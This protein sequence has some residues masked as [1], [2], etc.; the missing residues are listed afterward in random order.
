MNSCAVE[1][2]L[3]RISESVSDVEAKK[4]RTEYQRIKRRKYASLICYSGTGYLG[5]QRNPGR[6]TIEEDLLNAMLKAGAITEEAYN[7]PKVIEFQRAAR[8]DKG[9]SAVRQILSLKLPMEIS[10]EDI[11]SHLPE[12][13]RMVAVKRATKGFNCKGHCDAR[14]Y[15]YMMPS[16]ALAPKECL[17]EESYRITDDVFDKTNELLQ[18]FVGTHNY[19]NFTSRK[20]P[21][22]PSAQRYIISFICERPVLTEGME[23][24]VLKVKG[25]SFM[26]HQ[27]RK[28]VGLVIAIMRGVTAKETVTKAWG[29]EKLDLPVAPGVGLVLEEVHYDRY[30]ERYSKDGFHDA[31]E[32]SA[33]KEQ[34]EEFKTKYILSSI[35]QTEK[36]EKSMLLW[37]ENL[38]LHSFD[39]RNGSR[40]LVEDEEEEDD[41][42]EEDRNESS[43]LKVENDVKSKDE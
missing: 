7:Q 38:P 43:K 36:D 28:M 27:I 13:I 37:L 8:T 42:A 30:N 1:N 26:L 23:F 31:I 5:L 11:N 41:C 39:V 22:D 40:N 33:V 9:V 3:K 32:W 10:L 20:K 19:H 2:P 4:S 15:S 34:L 6:K 14:T 18:T 35:V 17:P 12:Q 29:E 25:Q 16:F 21:L 24:V